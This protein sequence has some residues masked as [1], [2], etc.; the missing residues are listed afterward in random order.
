MK[1]PALKTPLN[2]IQ[3]EILNLFSRDLEENEL[4]EIK[5]IL[6]QYLAKKA[7]RLANEVWDEKGWT[8]EDMERLSKTH[9]RTPYKRDK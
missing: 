5:K 2:N 8:Q 6:V 4:K 3:L 9:M 1:N 7:T